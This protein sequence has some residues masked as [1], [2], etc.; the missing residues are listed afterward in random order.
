M[1][2]RTGIITLKPKVPE[3]SFR[4]SV[5]VTNATG[6]AKESVVKVQVQFISEDAVY[7]SGSIKIDGK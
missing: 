6:G 7:S 3:M 1:A 2:P 4:F 5:R